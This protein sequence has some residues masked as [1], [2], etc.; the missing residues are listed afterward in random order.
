MKANT[1]V[2]RAF[3]LIAL[4]TVITLVLTYPISQVPGS[5]ILDLGPDTRLFLWT[6]S[7]DMHALMASPLELFDSNIFYPE[8]NTL[9]YTEHQIGSALLALPFYWITGNTVLAMNAVLLL[10]CL[11]SAL[12]TYYLARVSG[13]GRMG[14]LIAALIFAFAPPRF[15]R[16][17]QLHLASV[18]WIPLTLAFIHRYAASGSYR[19]LLWATGFFTLQALT[20]GQN[21]F[22]LCLA[23]VSLVGYLV[24]FCELQ[25]SNKLARDFF[26]VSMLTI[27]INAPF[28]FPYLKTQSTLGL[29]RSLH[30]AEEWAPH[31]ASFVAAPTHVQNTILKSFAARQWTHRYASAYLFPG[32]ITLCLVLVSFRRE[33]ETQGSDWKPPRNNPN[34][35]PATIMAIDG[36]IVLT[37]LA[38]LTIEAIDGFHVRIAGITV[39]AK[40]GLRV[41]AVFASLLFVRLIFARTIPFAFRAFL[42]QMREAWRTFANNRFGLLPGFYLMLAL[43]SLWAAL[44]PRFGLY[45]A[46]YHL[47]PGFDFIRVPSRFTILS[48]LG[49][50]MLA[51]VG[52][53]RL[54]SFRTLSRNSRKMVTAVCV[55]LLVTEFAA[56]PL[57]TST[58]T[59]QTTL[60]D[61][62]LAKQDSI[63]VVVSLP[64][65]D[66]RDD[67]EA[68]RRHSAYML[69]STAHFSQ[70]VNGYSGFTPAR[71][72]KL[73]QDLVNF[74]NKQSLTKLEELGV[75]FAVLYRGWYSKQEWETVQNKLSTYSNRL[76]LILTTQDGQ[77][78][79][80]TRR[81]DREW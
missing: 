2:G 79:A 51:G 78:W 31:A 63:P 46:L 50:A 45:A 7:W 17:G 81:H 62:W 14:A 47:L 61:Q 59:V 11:A 41:A 52:F 80:I 20:G 5:V 22:F 39:S 25:I 19:H 73:F 38:A 53:D 8:K 70:L 16:L 28:V 24:F 29:Q 18:Q 54:L 9:A 4:F 68:A 64:I 3:F 40:D 57:D 75:Q 36:L 58:Y 69:Y 26:L 77:I 6:L 1:L 23:I 65:V 72:H 49:L 21:A 66:P 42:Q 76:R 27:V 44:G 15:F 35:S 43:I 56:C 48:L 33:Q 34:R 10:S 37:G 67:V 74:P 30:E 71:H 13:I 55:L 32:W 12:G 60:M